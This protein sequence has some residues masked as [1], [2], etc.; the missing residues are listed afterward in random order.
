MPCKQ[1]VF[2]SLVMVSLLAGCAAPPAPPVKVKMPDRR[3][4]QVAEIK[5][6]LDKAVRDLP[7]LL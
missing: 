4:D 6:L 3:I 5:P 2:L 1:A 7:L